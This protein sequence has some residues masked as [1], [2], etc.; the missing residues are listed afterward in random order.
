M[1][2]FFRHL[3]GEGKKAAI[4]KARSFSTDLRLSYIGCTLGR[5]RLDNKPIG[6]VM[7]KYACY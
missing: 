2:P 3:H 4:S 7:Q 5:N 6:Y 1:P